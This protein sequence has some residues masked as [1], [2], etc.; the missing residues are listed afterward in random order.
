MCSTSCSNEAL[1]VPSLIHPDVERLRNRLNTLVLLVPG[2]F[3]PLVAA[4]WLR[5]VPALRPFAFEVPAP[6]PWLLLTCAGVMLLPA[7]LP[8]GYFRPRRF[9]RGRFYPALGLRAFRAVATD[10]DWI[11]RRLRRLDPSYRVVRDRR[12]RAEHVA[13]SITN[14]RWHTAFLLLGLVTTASALATGQHGWAIA[15]TVFNV[16]FNLYPVC[17]QRYKRARL[18]TI[19]DVIAATS[20]GRAVT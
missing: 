16:V 2:Q 12:T 11:N 15:I 7:F 8:R 19:P 1:L 9:E 10:G 3:F 20:S 13:G 6:P 14:E 5:F 18:R 4:Y 17:H